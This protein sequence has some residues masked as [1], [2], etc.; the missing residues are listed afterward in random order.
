[1]DDE[2][3]IKK[4]AAVVLFK[5]HGILGEHFEPVGEDRTPHDVEHRTANVVLPDSK[6][7]H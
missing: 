4:I 2:E 7:L 6:S 5:P 3:D 1:M